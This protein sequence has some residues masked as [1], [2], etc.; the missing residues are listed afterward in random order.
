[1]LCSAG[2]SLELKGAAIENHGYVNV[3]D[4]GMSADNDDSL[5]CRTNN[6]DCCSGIGQNALNGQWY[7]PNGTRVQAGSGDLSAL[8]VTN[9]SPGVVRLYRNN[10]SVI[11][12]E[13]GR[14][15]C[16]VPNMAGIVKTVYVNICKSVNCIQT[17]YIELA[18]MVQVLLFFLVEVGA[19]TIT[20]F[21][22][23]PWTSGGTGSLVC[24]ATT[25][26]PPNVFS[27]NF[28]WFFGPNNGSLPSDV[29]F[30]LT[31]NS[32][33]IYT[34]TLQFSSLIQRQHQGQ[35]TCRLGGNERLANS[36]RIY[37]KGI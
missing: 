29:T 12:P 11:P 20:R 22:Y 3:N 14:F 28:E 26:L 25:S 1:M 18:I 33:N 10:G 31:T 9:R 23:A 19:V 13:R 17:S 5:L 2:V 6:R 32:G 15:Y 21:P 37:V 8:F 7:Y 34:S 4:I 35:Y 27:P 30:P 36:D 24:S 16:R